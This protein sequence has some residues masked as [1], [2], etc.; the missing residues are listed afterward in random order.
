QLRLISSL[1]ALLHQLL[2]DIR[3]AARASGRRGELALASS[4]PGFGDKNTP[5]IIACLPDSWEQWG[6]KATTAKKLQAYFGC[7]PPCAPP[8]NGRARSSVSV[9]SSASMPGELPLVGCGDGESGSREVLRV[10]GC[11]RS[12]QGGGGIGRP[13]R[14]GRGGGSL[15]VLESDPGAVEVRGGGQ[16][17]YLVRHAAAASE[18]ICL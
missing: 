4:L 15:R 12:A 2:A 8:A 10:W 9:R 5:V 14:E 11:G 1:H 6:D 3:T 13:D 16:D 17:R 18:P 7:A